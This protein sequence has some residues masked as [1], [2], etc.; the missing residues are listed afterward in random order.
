[1]GF[2]ASLVTGK[3]DTFRANAPV[4][5]FQAQ[6]AQ[7]DH[8]NFG[9]GIDQATQAALDGN[10]AQQNFIN[11]LTAQSQGQ[12]PSVAQ[13]ML[14]QATDQNIQGQAGAMASAKGMNPALAARLIAQNGAA[15][16]QQSVGQMATLRAQEQLGTQGLLG[17]ALAN[18]RS[19]N[20]GLAGTLAGAQQGQ[21]ALGLQNSLGTQQIN[22]GVA[23]GNQQANL[24]AQRINAGVAGQN[25][26]FQGKILGGLAGGLGAAMIPKAHGGP[27]PG[28]A[29]VAGDSPS[30]DTVPAILS[31]GEVVL[32]RSVVNAEDAPDKAAAFV[33]AI[34]RKGQG[35]TT[36]EPGGYAK[37]LELERR[38]KKLEGKK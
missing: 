34:Q 19:Q 26:D 28:T 9:A 25:A 6:Q 7:L 18:Q 11:A 32:P 2:V 14:Q 36:A 17:Q 15:T 35:G 24:D 33:R 37:V 31:P 4:N 8:N 13:N 3:P 38:L 1:M 30:N 10:G 16:Q 23:A 12:G 22:A 27:I 20:I 29:A 5:T 21:N